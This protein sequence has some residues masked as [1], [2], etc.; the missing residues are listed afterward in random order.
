MIGWMPKSYGEVVFDE[1][2]K[3]SVGENVIVNNWDSSFNVVS[4]LWTSAPLTF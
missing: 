1:P 4:Y 2:R 3:R